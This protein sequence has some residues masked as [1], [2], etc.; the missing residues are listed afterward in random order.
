MGVM[1][2]KELFFVSRMKVKFQVYILIPYAK[3]QIYTGFIG[4][5]K[6]GQTVKK[7]WKAGVSA[8]VGRHYCGRNED[9]GTF[10]CFNLYCNTLC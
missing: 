2:V 10:I 5:Q 3:L 4:S 8:S 7:S 1:R 9:E 6:V